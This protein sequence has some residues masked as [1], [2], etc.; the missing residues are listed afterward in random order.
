MGCVLSVIGGTFMKTHNIST[1]H[2]QYKR[3]EVEKGQ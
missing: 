2:V 3:R 1:K